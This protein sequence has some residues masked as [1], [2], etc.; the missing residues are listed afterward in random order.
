M[1]SPNPTTPQEGT[2]KNEEMEILECYT[3]NGILNNIIE[4]IDL[5]ENSMPRKGTRLDVIEKLEYCIEKLND[6]KAKHDRIV[7]RAYELNGGLVDSRTCR[8]PQDRLS[9][10]PNDGDGA[11]CGDCGIRIKGRKNVPLMKEVKFKNIGTVSLTPSEFN[12][13]VAVTD[14]QNIR[15]YISALLALAN[16]KPVDRLRIQMTFFMLSKDVDRIGRYLDY[17]PGGSGPHSK[18]LD[19]ILDAMIKSGDLDTEELHRG[20][21]KFMSNDEVVRSIS[22]NYDVFEGMTEE[23]MMVFVGAGSPGMSEASGTYENVVKPDLE[24]HVMSLIRKDKITTGRGAKLLG[25]PYSE[26]R[27]KIKS[28]KS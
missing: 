8:H 10:I 1:A 4:L 2:D 13:P 12:K 14:E 5:F 26:M 22:D 23:E 18:R 7:R 3:D 19:E 28:V 20:G 25:I 17:A 16:N 27:N 9:R 15:T 24:K 11:Y 6:Q 21:D